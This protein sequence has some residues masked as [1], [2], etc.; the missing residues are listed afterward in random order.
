M[1]TVNPDILKWAR[2]TAGLDLETAARKISLGDA[3]GTS[4]ADRLAALEA[5]ENAASPALLKRMARQYHRP[6]LTFYMAEAP[7]PADIGEDYRTLPDRGDPSNVLLSTL[8]RDVKAR[9]ALVREALED[10]EEYNPIDLVG[11][12]AGVRD[13]SQLARAI[14]QSIAFDRDTFRNKSSID[15]A[16][17]YLR[18]LIEAKGIFVLLAGDCGH[19]STAIDVSI[20]RGFAIADALAPFIVVNDQD[21]KSAWS[22]TLLHELAHLLIGEG[23]ISGGLPQGGVER[24]C[25]DAAAATLISMVE[26]E[27]LQITGDSDDVS[28]IR[29]LANRAKVSRSMIAYQLYRGGRI[30]TAQWEGLRDEF[31]GDWLAHKAREKERSRQTEGGPNW[32]VVRRHRLGAALLAVARQGMADGS[33]TPT[34]AA[35]MLGVKPMNIYPLLA[36]PPRAFA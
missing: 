12:E 24:L 17:S 16:F 27:R 6:L 7:A 31:R 33:L 20:F 4:G 34:R 10:D 1:S 21:A 18:N 11:L 26:I 36:G 13:P 19:W 15:E 9:Q 30:S 22:F 32:Y 29:A 8:L 35:R 28:E 3:R 25:N 14:K 2:V 5:G 23:G